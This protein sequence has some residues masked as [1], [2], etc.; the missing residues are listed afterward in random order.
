MLLYPILSHGKLL[1]EEESSILWPRNADFASKRNG[2]SCS[3][4]MPALSTQGL[5]YSIDVCTKDHSCYYMTICDEKNANNADIIV[6]Q[7]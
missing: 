2:I 3:I 6:G 7:C 1:I 5:K 4:L